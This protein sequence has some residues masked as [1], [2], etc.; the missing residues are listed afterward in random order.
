MSLF[1]IDIRCSECS[2]ASDIIVSREVGTDWDYVHECPHCKQVAAKRVMSAPRI[3]KEAYHDGYKRGG[4]YQLLK[5]YA[6]ISKQAA[7]AS[8]S[9]KK[10]LENAARQIKRAA[11]QE[12]AKTE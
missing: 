10:E 12:K 2:E 8:G 11:R 3:F 9:A 7:G 5:E 4:D 6:K 1:S